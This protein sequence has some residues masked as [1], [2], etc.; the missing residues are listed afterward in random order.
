MFDMFAQKKYRQLYGAIDVGNLADVRR[1]ADDKTVRV[2]DHGGRNALH[3][4]VLFQRRFIVNELLKHFAKRLV[5]ATDSVRICI[6][7]YCWLNEVF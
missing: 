2:L 1:Y 7:R 3:R 4:A 6:Y 5:N